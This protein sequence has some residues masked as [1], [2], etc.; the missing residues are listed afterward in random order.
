MIGQR[1]AYTHFR[2]QLYRYLAGLLM[3]LPLLVILTFAGDGCEVAWGV[4][5]A[6][7][8]VEVPPSEGTVLSIGGDGA[9]F[10]S[11][12]GDGGILF[13]CTRFLLYM[14]VG[15]CTSNDRAECWPMT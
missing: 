12:D 6:L 10:S 2:A 5:S 8:V 11:P 1:S 9:G 14:P 13:I 7:L 3:T 4:V 15:V